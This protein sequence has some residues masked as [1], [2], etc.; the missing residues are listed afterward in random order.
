MADPRR[1]PTSNAEP[2][3][4]RWVKVLGAITLVL[5]LLLVVSLLAGVRHGPGLHTPSA[6]IG[7]LTTA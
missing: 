3:A 4:P 7:R 5:V 2:G 6:D 1:D